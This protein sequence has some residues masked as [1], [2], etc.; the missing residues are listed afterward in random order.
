MLELKQIRKSYPLGPLQID[1]LCGVDLTVGAGEMVAIRGTSG[2]GKSTLLNVIGLL[3]VPSAGSY[4]FGEMDVLKADDDQLSRVRNRDIGLVFQQY[5]L[6]PHLTAVDNVALPLLY[7][8][9]PPREMRER[10][11]KM[12]D[13]VGLS[14]RAS[15]M[16]SQLS[17]GQQQRV[18]I[19]RA[20]IGGP[21]VILADEPTGSLDPAAAQEIV[22]LFLSL[23]RE[24]KI[25]FLAVTHDTDV[26]RHFGRQVV[27]RAGLVSAS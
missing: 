14:E 23:N 3:D 9:T 19:A 12:L 13:R 10:A 27:L 17:G 22:D 20:L 5:F 2:V 11:L 4:R 16:P 1:V 25:T 6:L 18:A 7:R 15:H 8:D 24:E 26:A 21:K